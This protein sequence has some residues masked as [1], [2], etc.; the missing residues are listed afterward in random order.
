LNVHV[1]LQILMFSKVKASPG[2]NFFIICEGSCLSFLKNKRKLYF[3]T[4]KNQFK[5]I[6]LFGLSLLY[7]FII[8]M[9]SGNVTP[10]LFD[11]KT[12]SKTEFKSQNSF[13]DFLIRTEQS[14][15]LSSLNRTI[16]RTNFKNQVNHYWTNSITSEL[17]LFCFSSR[18]VFISDHPVVNFR[19]CDLI[20]PF[21]Y[22]W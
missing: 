11:Y 18:Y 4:V 13:T 20:F 7:C 12:Q 14:E 2:I 8:S 17:L 3:Y 19:K 21:H 15:S 10:N 22:F 16:P 5:I 6:A 9:Y 1:F